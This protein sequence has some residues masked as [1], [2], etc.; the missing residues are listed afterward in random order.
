MQV[1]LEN[2]VNKV[3]K[4]GDILKRL[5]WTII[6]ML[7]YIICLCFSSKKFQSL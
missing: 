3:N 2:K 7:D 1:T 6:L 5:Y 4:V